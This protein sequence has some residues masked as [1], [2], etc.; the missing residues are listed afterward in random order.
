MNNSKLFHRFLIWRLNYLSNRNFLLL[1][2]LLVGI[3]G[4]LAAVILKS[5]AHYVQHLLTMGF[6]EKYHN[7]LFFIYPL[8]GILLTVLYKIAFKA[9]NIGHGMPSLLSDI[10]KKRSYMDPQSMYHHIVTSTFTVGFG[11]SVGLEAPIVTTGAAI[12]SN[13]GRVFHLGYKKRTLLIGCGVAAG[14]SGIFNAPIT[15]IIFGFEVLMLDLSV[16]AFIPLLI[17]AVTGTIVAQVFLGREILFNFAITDVFYHREIPFYIVLGIITGLI[18][19]YFLRNYKQTL[20]ILEKIPQSF[21]RAIY[22]GLTLGLMIF[23]FPPLYGEGY[24]VIQD[25]LAGNRFSLFNESFFFNDITSEWFLLIFI[26]AMIFVKVF[27]SAATIG[28]GGNGGSFAPS[29]FN[30]G[31]IGYFFAHLINTID[32]LPFSL[33]ERDFILVGMAGM[34][35]GVLRAPMT[36]IFLIAEITSGYTLILPLMIVSTISYISSAYFEPHSVYL[37]QLANQGHI[38]FHD[39]DRT[40]LTVLEIK[41]LMEKDLIPVKADGKLK[42]LVEAVS[43]SKRNIFPVVD[44]DFKLKGVILLDDIRHLMFKPELYDKTTIKEL[45]HAAPAH[46]VNTETMEEVMA[47]FDSTSAWN[48]PVVDGVGTYLGFISKSKIFSHYRQ[49]LKQQVKEDTEIIE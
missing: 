19:V 20:E 3:C 23:I 18:S 16:P 6:P 24:G 22:G 1:I 21:R 4:G 29:M 25:L 47:K 49:M 11:G 10:S 36:G 26:G 12:G 17:S 42:D 44:S 37:R 7:Y 2:T 40:V 48:L 38:N 30:G 32:I 45:S 27:A 8:I 5:S 35:S 15:G 14:I 41:K 9:K 31:I 39:K 28:A 34:L 13:L 33:S 46:I 43:K